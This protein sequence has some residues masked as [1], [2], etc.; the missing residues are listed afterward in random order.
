MSSLASSK[1]CSPAAPAWKLRSC[2]FSSATWSY[3]HR[4][5]HDSKPLCL[6][7]LTNPLSPFNRSPRSKIA[8]TSLLWRSSL[9]REHSTK[10][11]PLWRLASCPSWKSAG[12]PPRYPWHLPRNSFRHTPGFPS[13]TSSVSSSVHI[14]MPIPRRRDW[15]LW[16][17]RYVD[18]TT[19]YIP[20]NSTFYIF[21][22]ILL[23]LTIY[24]F[25][26]A[27][28]LALSITD[29]GKVHRA[30]P[31]TTH[32][33]MIE[34]LNTRTTA[35]IAIQIGLSIYIYLSSRPLGLFLRFLLDRGCWCEW[36][37]FWQGMRMGFLFFFFPF[38]SFPSSWSIIA[39]PQILESSFFIFWIEEEGEWRRPLVP[40]WKLMKFYI[41]TTWLF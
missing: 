11:R 7:H 41:Y 32:Q 10:L 14:S 2:R 40:L 6:L 20:W 26:F 35:A 38:P 17:V 29:L 31:M 18:G 12:S 9:V 21:P 25:C 4:H 23:V 1:S 5:L 8:F 34:Y 24:H 30:G 19:L 15:R 39:W 37:I 13:S 36:T 16:D 3:V 28:C 27:F 22:I 33:D